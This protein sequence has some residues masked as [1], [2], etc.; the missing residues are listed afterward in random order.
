MPNEDNLIELPSF[1]ET[2]YKIIFN[3]RRSWADLNK[4][5]TYLSKSDLSSW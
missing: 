4:R 2:K 3:K 5:R 1:K